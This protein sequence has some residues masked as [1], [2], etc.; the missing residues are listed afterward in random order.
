MQVERVAAVQNVLGEGPMWD[1][2]EQVLCW[3]DIQSDCFYRY[4]PQGS[5][6]ERFDVGISVGTLALR[7]RG[8]FVLATRNGFA[9]WD[10]ERRALDFIGD[11]E[12]HLP[13]TRF[14]D[15]VVD[16]NGRFWA[17]TMATDGSSFAGSLYRLD[18]DGTIHTMETGIGVSNGTGWSPDLKT[19]YYAD[20]PTSTIFAYDFDAATGS[21]A[22][23]RPFAV[24]PAGEGFP[25]GLTVDSEGCIW[26]A[27]W[28]GW[29]VVR[30][31]PAGQ[32]MTT[33]MMPVQRPT[34]CMFGG[35][36]LT[37]LYITSASVG[38][39]E[40]DKAQQPQAG[41][42]FRVKTAV[43]GMAEHKFAG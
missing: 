10:L 2:A 41:D 18:P 34:S 6:V 29:R 5:R 11:P 19:M 30:Y 42:L 8:G 4:F 31:D 22:N 12:A 21:I 16:A 15:G 25:D 9:Y 32:L 43:K 17:G 7:Q 3:V 28:D 20:S 39:S 14:N 36:D 27:R 1:A 23:K 37:E 38:L 40:A 35:A 24:A 33:L 26:S 13:N